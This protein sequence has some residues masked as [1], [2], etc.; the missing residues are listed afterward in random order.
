MGSIIKTNGITLIALV[1]TIIVLLIL[2]GVT[3]TTL[4][5]ENGILNKADT[6][7]VET[8]AATV[9]ELVRLWK[10]EQ[11]ADNMIGEN[12]TQTLGQ[13]LDK[14]EEENLITQEERTIIEDDGEITI[15][16]KTIIF[17]KLNAIDKVGNKVNENINDD[18]SINY[19]K[20]KEDLESIKNIQGVPENLGEDSFLLIV[21][22]NGE[23]VQINQDGTVR[24]SNKC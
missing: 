24:T 2:A 15:G 22:I 7:Q 19:E 17:E 12:K 9:E 1:I 11:T 14:L 10:T 5:G 13:L 21:E 16:N 20:L 3:I 6:A 8:R 4:T 23:L 18:G